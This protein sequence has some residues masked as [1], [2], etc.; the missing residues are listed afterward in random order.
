MSIQKYYNFC[1]SL[2]SIVLLWQVCVFLLNLSKRDGNSK[3]GHLIKEDQ[4]NPRYD[5]YLAWRQTAL[6]KHELQW[7][8]IWFNNDP[9]INFLIQTT[10]SHSLLCPKIL[11]HHHLLKRCLWKW[12]WKI[13]QSLSR[14][15]ILSHLRQQTARTLAKNNNSVIIGRMF[16]I[17]KNVFLNKNINLNEFRIKLKTQHSLLALP[18]YN[19]NAHLPAT[20]RQDTHDFLLTHYVSKYAGNDP[21][22]IVWVEWA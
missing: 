17:N 20:E 11:L 7:Q 18:K 15:S 6:W 10:F 3:L 8:K 2:I 19:I 14:W 9:A 1:L 22:R 21:A 5:L 4:V 13:R 12:K 16:Q